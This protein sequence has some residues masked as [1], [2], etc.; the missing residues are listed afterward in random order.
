MIN[1]KR[2]G[3]E[4][5][6]TRLPTG[7]LVDYENIDYSDEKEIEE[8]YGKGSNP[9]GYGSGN[10]KAE[11]KVTML[12]EEFQRSIVAYANSTRR[13]IY[14]LPPFPITV[15]Y[16]NE[17][18]PTVTDVLRQCKI[19]KI[20]TSGSQGESD[21]KVELEL[22]VLGGIRWGSANAN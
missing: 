8:K 5:I 3:W 6:S 2:Y 7:E 13:T 18:N 20:S 10:Y 16:A 22:A 9:R 11:A 19:K 12:R 17:D 14:T 21:V 1:G 4:D 15:S